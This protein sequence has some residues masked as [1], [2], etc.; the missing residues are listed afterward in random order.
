M[1]LCVR[2][3][4]LGHARLFTTPW[5]VAH[6]AALSMG[7]PRQE[8]WSRL[9]C[10]PPGDPPDPGIAPRLSCLLHWQ[11]GSSLLRH[12]GSPRLGLADA[13]YYRW[14]GINNNAHC[15]A[16]GTIFNILLQIIMEEN[17]F[18]SK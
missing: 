14:N 10:P 6:Q 4:T 7:F 17:I 16:Q 13:N 3:C 8:Y 11:A 1:G 9:P 2:E 5:T 18:K 15:R 12:L